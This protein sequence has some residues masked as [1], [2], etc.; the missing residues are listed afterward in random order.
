[1]GIFSVTEK[2]AFGKQPGLGNIAHGRDQ[3]GERA[4]LEQAEHAVAFDGVGLVGLRHA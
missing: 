2:G 1:M 4:N 3:A